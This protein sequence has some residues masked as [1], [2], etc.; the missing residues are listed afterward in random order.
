MEL[1][2]SLSKTQGEECNSLSELLQ[3]EH[4]WSSKGMSLPGLYPWNERCKE[5]EPVQNSFHFGSGSSRV[6]CQEAVVSEEEV[7]VTSDGA[8]NGRTANGGI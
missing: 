5:D 7:T 1:S 8:S 2:F 6:Q 4:L 3:L